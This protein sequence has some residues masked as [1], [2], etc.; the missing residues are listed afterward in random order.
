M[1]IL[2]IALIVLVVIWSII[3]I[4]IA[5]ALVM[6]ILTIRKAL[7]KANDIID[8][9]HAVAD[10]VDLPSKVVI[11]TIVGFLAKNSLGPIIR[12]ISGF[13]SRKKS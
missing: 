5:I 10:K 3:F 6:L 1:S 8:K 12:T 13:L 7:V 9:T 11:A 2:E 4:I